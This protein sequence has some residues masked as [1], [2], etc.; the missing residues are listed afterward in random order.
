MQWLFPL[1]FSGGLFIIKRKRQ[2]YLLFHYLFFPRWTFVA[3][4]ELVDPFWVNEKPTTL[5]VVLSLFGTFRRTLLKPWFTDSTNLLSDGRDKY[6]SKIIWRNLFYLFILLLFVIRKRNGR[7]LYNKPV[8]I[9]LL[10]RSVFRRD[11]L[12]GHFESLERL[13]TNGFDL[14]SW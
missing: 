13:D 9:F 2:P 10:M 4:R 1:L 14:R 7:S 12:I 11:V 3:I 8:V 5:P 6:R